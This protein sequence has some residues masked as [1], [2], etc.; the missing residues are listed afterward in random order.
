MKKL[1][2]MSLG[3]FYREIR[4]ARKVKQCEVARGNLTASQ[5]SKFELGQSMLSA[6]RLYLAIEGVNMTFAEFG[7]AL[8]NYQDRPF[9]VLGNRIRDLHLAGDKDGLLSLSL[10]LDDSILYDRLMIVVIKA[11][12]YSLDATVEIK[13]SDI[14]TLTTYLYDIERWTAFE[15]YLFSTTTDILDGLDLLYL[16]RSLIGRS[17]FY[18][19]IPINRH[20]TKLALI[21]TIFSLIDKG[22]LEY[23]TFFQD[24]LARLIDYEDIFESVLLEFSKYIIRYLSNQDSFEIVENYIESLGVLKNKKIQDLLRIRL[25]SYRVVR[26]RNIDE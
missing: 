16:A 11:T 1:D 3:E 5:L 13:K 8:N 26:C 24:A 20:N 10:S 18:S 15:L 19:S 4:Q 23:T 12:L 22:L 21:N 6:D 2:K 14:E 17:D 9:V 7:H 25:E